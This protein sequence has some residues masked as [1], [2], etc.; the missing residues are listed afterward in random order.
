MR[1]KFIHSFACLFFDDSVSTRYWISMVR[2]RKVTWG[3]SPQHG[4]I[5]CQES[6][7]RMGITVNPGFVWWHQVMEPLKEHI[8]GAGME[9]T[10][11]LDSCLIHFW[12]HRIHHNA[13]Q[14]AST[15]TLVDWQC[16]KSP[17]L[18]IGRHL[19]KT[20]LPCVRWGQLGGPS[21]PLLPS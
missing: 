12:I 18:L 15:Q 11:K 7:D 9:W 19:K 21:L 3:V 14:R 8:K 17:L 5:R 6:W 20:H 16:H 4:G 1:E 2:S 13:W 10:D